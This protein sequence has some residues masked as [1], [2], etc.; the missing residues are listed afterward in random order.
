MMK[1]VD[2]TSIAPKHSRPQQDGMA[3]LA[4]AHTQAESLLT[5]DLKFDREAF[6]EKMKKLIHRLGS[7]ASIGSR[8]FEIDDFSHSDFSSMS[9]FDLRK[10]PAGLGASA[11]M[12]FFSKSTLGVMERFYPAGHKAPQGIV[13]VT[14]TGYVS[15]SAAQRIVDLRAWNEHTT[16]THL[17]HMG[18]AAAFPAIRVALGFHQNTDIVHTEQCTL[19]LNP[20]IRDFEQIVMQILFADGFIKYTTAELSD[21][22]PGLEVIAL[23]EKIVPHSQEAMTWVM[24]DWGMK[25]TL[26][27]EVPE[28]IG[29]ELKKF[30]S[31]LPDWQDSFY[32]D[33]IFAI[34]PGGP[35]IID[36]V[37]KLL[38]LRDDQIQW[39]RDVL[40]ERGNMSSATLPHVWQK[41]LKDPAV[42]PGKVIVSMAF[43]PG[44]TICGGIFRK[45]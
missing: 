1:L 40:F 34:H 21:P 11:R 9:V 19:H 39:S 30:L 33:A 28:L 25:M 43:A 5:K 6:H 10:H 37:Q 23:A 8:S 45:V 3:W 2:F 41:L 20:T 31:Q 35:K 32:Q 38:G 27:R 16:V 12:E 7:G 4:R 22:R 14:C 24:S 42:N 26:A 15:P 44:L 18:C 17:Y 13:H 36:Q 29:A